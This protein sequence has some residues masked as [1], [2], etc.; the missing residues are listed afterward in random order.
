MTASQPIFG[1]ELKTQPAIE[2]YDPDKEAEVAIEYFEKAIVESP[3]REELEGWRQDV[4]QDVRLTHGEK[5]RLQNMI[6]DQEALLRL[7]RSDTIDSQ[8]INVSAMKEKAKEVAA[9]EDNSIFGTKR[10]T[11]S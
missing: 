4:E 9:E 1:N 2:V 3:T 5:G 7:S 8:E 10:T 11:L 6:D